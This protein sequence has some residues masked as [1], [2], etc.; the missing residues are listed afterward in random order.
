MTDALDLDQ[1]EA[2]ALWE[3][4]SPAPQ[5]CPRCDSYHISV[6][7]DGYAD[8]YWCQEC[9]RTF[10]APIEQPACPLMAEKQ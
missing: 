7:I 3:N 8:A 9:Q 4:A 2:A 5:Q 10:H 1:D 6:A